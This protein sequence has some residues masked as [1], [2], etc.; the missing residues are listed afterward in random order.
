MLPQTSQAGASAWRLVP[1]WL[2]GSATMARRG[3]WPTGPTGSGDDV[4]CDSRGSGSE[5]SKDLAVSSSMR[6]PW[7]LPFFLGSGA[8]TGASLVGVRSPISDWDA[9]SD[10]GASIS[11]EGLFLSRLGAWA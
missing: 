8:G 1:C 7:P 4:V 6:G 10:V 2:R 5:Y 9:A 3:E 11:G